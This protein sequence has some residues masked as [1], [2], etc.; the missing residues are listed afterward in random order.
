M[1]RPLSYEENMTAVQLCTAYDA[2]IRVCSSIHVRTKFDVKTAHT[3]IF[4]EIRDIG[5]NNIRHICTV[6][7]D[8]FN[9]EIELTGVP[10][11][12]LSNRSSN[13]D[14]FIIQQFV[15]HV[16]SFYPATPKR[17]Q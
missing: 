13:C 15:Q 17:N 3:L 5:I 2:I 7:V 8:L 11:A 1:L 14:W 9:T 6:F 4:I 10:L 16:C 12:I